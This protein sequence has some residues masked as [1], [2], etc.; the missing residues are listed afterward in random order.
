MIAFINYFS[1]LLRGFLFLSCIL[2]PF[3]HLEDKIFSY[4]KELRAELRVAVKDVLKVY[5]F[6]F[7]SLFIFNTSK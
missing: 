6:V 5:K 7:L 1:S 4:L 3:F 2:F